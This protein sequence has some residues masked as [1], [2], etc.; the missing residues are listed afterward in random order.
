M[1]CMYIHVV[2]LSCT[3]LWTI[4]A[5]LRASHNRLRGHVARGT[6]GGKASGDKEEEEE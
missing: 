6:G 5:G 1:L 2:Q 3:D 4:G